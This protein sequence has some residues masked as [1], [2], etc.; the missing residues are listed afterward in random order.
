MLRISEHSKFRIQWTT[1]FTD[2]AD[3]GKS[4]L[5]FDLVRAAFVA[6][7]VF[8]ASWFCIWLTRESGRVATI[9]IANG[10]VLA[11]IVDAS[12]R[13]CVL[14]LSASTVANIFAN[15]FSGD[16]IGI[17][18]CLSFSNTIEIAVAAALL[19]CWA[20]QVDLA[21]PRDL[22]VFI[23]AAGLIAPSL[24]AAFASLS[25]VLGAGASF[26]PVWRAWMPT[27]ALGTII[28][29]PLVMSVRRFA[30]TS[31]SASFCLK[32]F[33]LIL[34][35]IA[36]A[37]FVFSQ[38]RYP[39]LFLVLPPLIL[40]AFT[41]NTIGSVLAVTLVSMIAI[42]FT[43]TSQGPLALIQG[44][45][46][47]RVI[48]LQ[49]FLAT[50]VFVILSL[51]SVLSQRKSLKDQLEQSLQLANQASEA[52]TDFLATMSHEIRTPLSGISGFVQ[53]LRSRSD[54]P[55]SAMR[56]LDLISQASDALIAVVNDILDFTKI[57]AG[58]VELFEKPFA[59]LG[60][61]DNCVSIVRPVADLKRLIL[62][63]NVMSDVQKYVVGDETRLRQVLLNLLNNAVK[64]SEHGS[65][66]LSVERVPLS[67]LVS[68]SVRDSGVGIAKDKQALLFERFSQVHRGDSRE[69][70]GTGLGLAICKQLVTLM[71]GRIVV[72]SE[73]GLGS[74]FK[75]EVA[76]PSSAT[77]P[78]DLNEGGSRSQ[79]RR[80]ASILLVEDSVINREIAAAMLVASGHKIQIAAC[81]EDAIEL[82]GTDQYD[83]IL[84]DIQ[85]PGLDGV[86]TAQMI[87]SRDLHRDTPIV[88]MTA[89]V[90]PVEVARYLSSGFQ[91]HLGKPFRRSDLLSMIDTLMAEPST[92]QG[93]DANNAERIA[94]IDE[95]EFRSTQ[96]KFQISLQDFMMRYETTY[97]TGILAF[98][99]HEL[100]EQAEKL[101]FS[102]LSDKMRLLEIAAR[103]GE[104]VE[105]TL[106][107]AL[108]S[109]LDALVSMAMS[110]QDN[111]RAL[112][113]LSPG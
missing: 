104:A 61:I 27:D 86:T 19:R 97:E 109:L 64:F 52:K 59:L 82:A 3:I 12:I 90:L 7:L 68:F 31:L 25:L 4:S 21:R 108:Q 15:I 92:D 85:M 49:T 66:V 70:G 2:A 81:G 17:A 13:R 102:D 87:R 99:A 79:K 55:K 26:W 96:A 43:M 40:L 23:L 22:G 14:L 94:T 100:I 11:F 20:P 57:E 9:W 73:L 63:I 75:F 103:S 107:A 84:M 28:V 8:A 48:L 105:R 98:D 47:E 77:P 101:G 53:L 51:V 41:G 29:V 42:G 34:L 36:T 112:S 62:K 93:N 80:S 71:G 16:S 33:G 37:A 58:Q 74:T 39:F 88:A 72:D 30:W 83:V 46:S 5:A 56:Q 54:I 6:S 44:D 95:I 89:N 45:L 113:T 38:S 60:L 10:I 76:L 18:A 35:S 65:I 32:Q 91:A 67:G 50:T 1:G 78:P 110:F 24:A 106:D 69:Y 111:P